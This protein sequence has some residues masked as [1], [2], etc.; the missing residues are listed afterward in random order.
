[1]TKKASLMVAGLS[2][3]LLSAC[4]ATPDQVI[5][6]AQQEAN[7]MTESLQIIQT[8]EADLQTD[9]ETDLAADKSLANMAEGGQGETRANLIARQDAFETLKEDYENLH[10][11]AATLK[12]F[13]ETDFT[14]EEDFSNFSEMRNLVLTVDEQMAGY[15]E[16][17]QAVLDAE[18]DYYQQLAAEDSDL[19]VFTDGMTGI[20]SQYQTAQELLA[21]VL[22]N[23]A[24]LAEDPEA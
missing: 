13:D 23:L 21:E 19:T 22:P 12:K 14:A 5:S 11:Q 10:N 17:Y 24:K 9:F 3:L 7:D 8:N 15:V 1:M 2:I 18:N 6:Q 16:N 4:G 20:N